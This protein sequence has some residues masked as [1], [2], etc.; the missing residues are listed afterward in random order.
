MEK[1]LYLTINIASIFVPF[2]ASFYTK[3]AFYKQ[4][5]TFFIANTIVATIFIIWDIYFTNIGVWG[6]NDR[7]I[8]GKRFFL[9]PIEEIMFFFF[10]PYASVFVYFSVTY[11][12]KKQPF[13][14]IH[15]KITLFFALVLMVIGIA[16]INRLYTSVT[17]IL[18]SIF[19]LYNY[20]KKK[21]LSKIY[22]SY[23]ITLVFFLL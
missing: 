10:I 18:C 21:D 4:W 6:F 13:A 22:F 8:I 7:Y 3:H 14:A 12:I 5:K 9:I 11:L 19:L 23:V 16:F 17:F 15:Q 20:F 2:L 1:Y